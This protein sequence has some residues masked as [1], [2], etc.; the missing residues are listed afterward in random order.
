MVTVVSIKFN[1][2]SIVTIDAIVTELK[3]NYY[4]TRKN[5]DFTILLENIQ[6][7]KNK[8]M[9]MVTLVSIKFS[10]ESIVTI[11]ITATELKK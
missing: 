1:I 10:I 9:S 5:V 8:S 3:K 4:K 2:E 6:G 7:R 11:N